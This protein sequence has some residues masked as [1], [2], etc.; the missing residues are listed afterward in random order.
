MGAP[1]CIPSTLP[2]C[3]LI[4]Q[5]PQS[6]PAP[7]PPLPSAHLDL[8]AL[9]HYKPNITSHLLI[10]T[11]IYFTKSFF[12][13]LS[14]LPLS[15]TTIQLYFGWS[16]PQMPYQILRSTKCNPVHPR[17]FHLSQLPK[18][19]AL[20]YLIPK[21]PVNSEYP[22]FSWIYSLL[23]SNT[24]SIVKINHRRFLP[25]NKVG[26]FIFYTW[27]RKWTISTMQNLAF[28]RILKWLN[29]HSNLDLY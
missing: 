8:N 15:P 29:C 14:Q 24:T 25:S 4:F 23:F 11:S 21:E 2:A 27:Y 19:L 26:I 13:P 18:C 7:S 1:A 9:S 22:T 5:V 16:L 12:S 17:L 28:N 20:L 6:L 10:V 3:F